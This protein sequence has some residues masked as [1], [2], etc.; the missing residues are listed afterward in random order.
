M[1]IEALTTQTV[2]YGA[3]KISAITF[4]LGYAAF[5]FIPLSTPIKLTALA[6]FYLL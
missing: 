1:I 6:Y 5:Q 2:L 4:K 3:F